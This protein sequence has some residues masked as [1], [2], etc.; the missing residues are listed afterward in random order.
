MRG[1]N[2]VL[3][4]VIYSILAT[5]MLFEFAIELS[6]QARS[7]YPVAAPRSRMQLEQEKADKQKVI[8]PDEYSDLDDTALPGNRFKSEDFKNSIELARQKYYQALILIQKRDTS[9]AARYFDQALEKLNELSG[10]PGIEESKDFTDLAQSIIDDYENYVKSIEFL[11]ENSPIFIIRELLFKEIDY[12][13]PIDLVAHDANNKDQKP[14]KSISFPKLPKAPDSLIIPLDDDITVDRSIQWLT[15]GQ[16]KKIFS[17]WLER[18]SKWFPM[19]K[20]IAEEENMP[21]EIIYL[22]MIESGL[23]PT[24]I[25]KAK[26]LGLW[27]FMRATGEAYGL[28]KNGSVFVD[29]RREP[30]KATRAAMRHLRD[31]YNEFGDWYLAMAA[32]NCGAGCVARAI[33]R[34]NKQNPNYWEVRD[35]LP[36]ETRGYVPQYIAAARLAIDPVSYGFEIDSLEF[37]DEYVYETVALDSAVN[38]SA[39]AKAAGISLDSLKMFNTELIKDCTPPDVIPY[40]LKLPV[41][42]KNNFIANYS[43]LTDEEKMPFVNH[44]VQNKETLS[45]IAKHYNVS[46][47]DIVTVNK[48]KGT[49]AKVSKG[50][51][52]IIPVSGNTLVNL[53]KIEAEQSVEKSQSNLLVIK[54]ESVKHKV[55]KGETLFS[56]AKKFEMEVSELRRLND[57]KPEEESINAGEELWVKPVPAD[58]ATNGNNN[59]PGITKFTKKVTSTQHKVK[60]GETLAQIADDYGVTIE[61]IKQSNNISNTNSIKV[62]QTINIQSTSIVSDDGGDKGSNK[63]VHNV[64]SGEN[65]STIAAKYSVTEDELRNWNPQAI[66]GNTVYANTKLTIYTAIE[67]KGSTGAKASSVKNAPKHYKIRRGDTLGKIAGKFGVSVNSIKNLNKNLDENKLQIGKTIRIQ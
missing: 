62:G 29:E 40:N 22:S 53:A 58:V 5:F 56:I 45:S 4:M 13:E 63:V 54:N 26:A 2:K 32:Y 37:I 28:N 48:L 30:E 7:G 33:R 43:L 12:I 57:I 41:G 6:A 52:L 17:R 42:T 61:S 9:R 1:R 19:M 47:N 31:L 15:R 11:D 14:N 27:Q 23:N 8:F 36:R 39:L 46:I 21:M 38:L 49:K 10:T 20:R 34:T 65:L 24:I 50:T 59:S 44:T 3:N 55:Q 25:S 51:N 60:R 66:K 35:N 64:K 16:G 18:S 67:S